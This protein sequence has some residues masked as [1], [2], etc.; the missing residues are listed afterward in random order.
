MR[1]R[2]LLQLHRELTRTDC[3]LLQ[4]SIQCRLVATE[5]LLWAFDLI[6]DRPLTSER[7][8]LFEQETNPFFLRSVR[9]ATSIFELVQL[10]LELGKLLLLLAKR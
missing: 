7:I 6:E 4:Q 8:I 2:Q 9:N 5:L 1:V 10:F 3:T